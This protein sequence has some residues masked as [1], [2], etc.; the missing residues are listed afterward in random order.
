M[1]FKKVEG[2]RELELAE[3]WEQA[4][5]LLQNQWEDCDRD[6]ESSL[7]LLAECW[8]VGCMWFRNVDAEADAFD[9]SQAALIEVY[10]YC[11]A[12]FADNVKYL[13]MCGYMESIY[14][15]FFYLPGEVD[16][17]IEFESK[18]V[19]MIKTA[20][21][22]APGDILVRYFYAMIVENKA[23]YTHWQKCLGKILHNYFS[24]E[25]EIERYFLGVCSVNF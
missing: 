8:F 6:L 7:R 12:N 10:E 11:N 14:P 25:T 2:L 5:I 21:R 15:F 23:R 9:A 19:D 18:A 16:R 13:I 17:Y 1:F 24:E 22:L 20:R 4:S 3:Q